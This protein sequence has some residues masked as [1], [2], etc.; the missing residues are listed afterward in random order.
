MTVPH[1]RLGLA[2]S[3]V[4]LRAPYLLPLSKSTRNRKPLAAPGAV[5]IPNIVVV[6]ILTNQEAGYNTHRYFVVLESI[7]AQSLSSSSWCLRHHLHC[8][9]GHDPVARGSSAG[10]DASATGGGPARHGGPAWTERQPT[11]PGHRTV[12]SLQ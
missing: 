7:Y 6:F 2:S 3:A 1:K 9:C 12:S 11:C 10:R 8:F 5:F 4:S